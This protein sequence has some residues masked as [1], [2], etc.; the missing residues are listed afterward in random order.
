MDL[1]GT[2]AV[3]TGGASGLG[4]ATAQTLMAAGAAVVVLDRPD[5]QGHTDR[6]DAVA[7]LGGGARYVAGD[8]TDPAAVSRAIQEAQS[9]AP[10]RVAVAC[11]GVPTPGKLVGGSGPLDLGRF[12]DVLSVNTG[13]TMTL[14]AQ[15]AEAMQ[16]LEPGFGPCPEDRG[17]L[18][19]TASIA[20]FEG[21][22]GQIAYAASKGGVA[23][24]TLP[25]ARELA[26]SAVRV[27][28]I[29]PGLFETPMMAD[30]PEDAVE[31]LR[32]G[33][34]HPPRLGRSADYARMVQQVITNPML[35]GEVIRLDGAI[36]L[37]PQ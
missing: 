26:A 28:T 34:L 35:N 16:R 14:M 5:A 13:G 15:A 10:L 36:R 8:V 18:I 37:A 4:F 30:L 24:M 22:I 6:Y 25:A 9:L 31:S 21:Q 7:S 3:I 11:A 2:S 12:M 19:C 20:A 33:T 17:V 23:S 32:A 29:A 27:V 1:G